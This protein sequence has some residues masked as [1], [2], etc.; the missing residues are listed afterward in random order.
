MRVLLAAAMM[1]SLA[2]PALAQDHVQRYGEADKDK[3]PEQKAADKAAQDAYKRSLGNIPDQ[4]P[5]DPW[6]VVRGSTSGTTP[7]KVAVAKTKK[8]KTGSAEA[9]P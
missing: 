5:T 4:G 3:T 8:T 1:V 7:P 9:K 2:G 6:G